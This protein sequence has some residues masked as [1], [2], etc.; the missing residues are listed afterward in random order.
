MEKLLKGV[1]AAPGIAIGRA[2]LR[3]EALALNNAPQI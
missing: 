1:P 2:R 3:S